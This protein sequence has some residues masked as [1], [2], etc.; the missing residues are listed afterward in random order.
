MLLL[1]AAAGAGDL[2]IRYAEPIE[3]QAPTTPHAS[4]LQAQI[5]SGRLSFLAYG[6]QF[7]LALEPNSRLLGTQALARRAAA[8]ANQ[9][10]PNFQLLRGR[11]EGLPGS[12]VRLTRIGEELHG[13]IWDGNELYTIEPA[14]IVNRFATDRLAVAS[15]APVVYRLSDS[16]AGSSPMSCGVEVTDQ[17][18]SAL[19]AY[20]ALVDEL[21]TDA[22]QSVTAGSELEIAVIADYEFYV[23]HPAN[24]EAELLA[25][26]NIVDGIFSGQLGIDI[27]VSQVKVFTTASEPFNTNKG[28]DLLD[29]V[30]RYRNSTPE[31]RAAGLA[32]LITGRDIADNMAGIAYVGTVCDAAHGVAVSEGRYDLTTTALISAHEI[33]HNFGASHDAEAGSPCQ[34]TAPT[35]LMAAQINGSK[36]FSQCSLEHMRPIAARSSC[37]VSTKFADASIQDTPDTIEGTAGTEVML[38]V[39]VSSIGSAQLNDV[40]VSISLQAPVAVES[41]AVPGGNCAT[42]AGG[43]TCQLGTIEARGTRRLSV[44]LRSTSPGTFEGT[45]KVSTPN[46]TNSAND[47]RVISLVMNQQSSPAPA[48]PMVSGGS[49]G[50]GG[51]TGVGLLIALSVALRRR[52]RRS[53]L[54]TAPVQAVA[55]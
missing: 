13:A 23:A 36:I 2:H 48:G 50:G 46:D 25:R 39:E 33:G 35:Y 30:G 17:R 11:I 7:D 45:V 3:L 38:P 16:D 28:S 49:G 6:R 32:H 27:V 20:H 10:A 21:G 44:A 24:T 42:G 22:T 34:G 51:A 18:R 52:F 4:S 55:G 31:L 26:M 54:R 14:R 43:V 1:S 5:A 8:A 37:I 29:E 19:T 47:M 12:W 53:A 15:S 41:V 9:S 40:Q